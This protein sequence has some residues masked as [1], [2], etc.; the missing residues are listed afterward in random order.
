MAD[1]RKRKGK[2]PYQV[3]F[4]DK[5]K[6]KGVGYRS[7]SRWGDANKFKC[8]KELEEGGALQST[9][10][11]T[12]EEAID[13]WLEICR[14]EGRRNPGEPVSLATMEQYEYRSRIMKAYHWSASLQDLEELHLLDFRSWLLARYSRDTA[15]KVMSSFHSVILTMKSRRI[16]ASDPAENVTLSN[17]SRYKEPV[18]IPSVQDFLTI[19]R[20]ADRLANSKNEQIAKTWARYRPM[21]YL[22]ADSGMRPQEY[23][24]LPPKGLL[25]SGIEVLQALDRSNQIGPPKTKAGRRFIPVGAEALDM[26]RQYA[27]KHGNAVFV[28]PT[29]NGGGCQLY[30]HYLRRGW[31]RLM[32]EAGFTEE[33]RKGGEIRFVRK[34]APYALRHFFASVLI[35][36]NKSPKYIQ[37][38][39]GHEDIKMTFDVYGHLLRKK[40]LEK[41][42]DR[43][44][45]LHYID[46]DTCGH[47]VADHA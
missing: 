28:F 32:D 33:I 17:G 2:K 21:I 43:G 38:V 13:K 47:T 45:I 7:F 40:E 11:R 23:L 31:H 1:I 22:A 35:D 8:R 29:R 16:I 12:V 39:M 44:G 15:Q 34:Y 26:A 18:Q 14:T 10:I 25:A 36:E 19:L 42:E 37:S 46:V 41:S 9:T 30:R 24:A 20:A 3:R 4:I 5:S 27:M 6:K